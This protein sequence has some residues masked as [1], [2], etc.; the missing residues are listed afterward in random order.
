MAN[1]CGSSV[2]RDPTPL[3]SRNGEKWIKYPIQ[4][5]S[6]AQPARLYVWAHFKC[7]ICAYS[8]TGASPVIEMSL[9]Q[10]TNNPRLLLRTRGQSFHCGKP[11]IIP[12]H[13][14]HIR[15][16]FSPFYSTP[17]ELGV[18]NSKGPLQWTRRVRP[19]RAMSEPIYTPHEVKQPLY[20]DAVQGKQVRLS[21]S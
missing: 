7:L 14:L 12:I 6:F 13:G 16:R 9:L 20:D 15:T 8:V 3:D 4:D 19:G 5:V 17:S 10:Y 21:R 18:R 11:D 1:D 2:R